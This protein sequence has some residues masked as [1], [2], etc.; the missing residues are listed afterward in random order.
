MQRIDRN[1]DGGIRERKRV[2]KTKGKVKGRNKWTLT[3]ISYK[4]ANREKKTKMNQRM[5][6]KIRERKQK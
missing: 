4:Q 1:F 3:N 2:E 5:S 6:D